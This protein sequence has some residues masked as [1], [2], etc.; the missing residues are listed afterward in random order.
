MIVIF[1]GPPGCGKGT[2]SK[3]LEKKYSCLHLSTG[4]MMRDE[5]GS[6]SVLGQS[7]K[8]TMD[9]GEFIEDETVID[10]LKS[11][12]QKLDLSRGA[13]FD[14]FPRTI[15]QAKELDVIL[16]LY[17]K[18][19]SHVF[20]FKVDNEALVS[21]VISRYNCVKCGALYNDEYR[22]T[23][24]TGVCDECGSTELKRRSDDSADTMRNR[25]SVFDA[26]TAPIVDFYKERGLVHEIDGMSPID[27][28][29]KK[30]STLLDRS[31]AEKISVRMVNH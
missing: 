5:V 3:I 4:D 17:N 2:Q 6:G 12:L 14:G 29:T 20:D 13:I 21:R 28:V 30:I 11:Q 31:S 25:L 22:P 24:V 27:E 26:D 19:V 9:K 18:E 8:N 10:I 23:K 15:S 16:N 7:I 1:I